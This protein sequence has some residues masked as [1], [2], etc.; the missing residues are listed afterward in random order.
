MNGFG[1]SAKK[2]WRQRLPLHVLGHLHPG[3]RASGTALAGLRGRSGAEIVTFPKL[4][5][6]AHWGRDMKDSSL[7]G[8]RL[9]FY[10]N[11]EV[12]SNSV[13]LVTWTAAKF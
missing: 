9:Y 4:E 6:E 7:K 3:R 11:L 12:W 1:S 8:G 13:R 2:A 10:V 5:M